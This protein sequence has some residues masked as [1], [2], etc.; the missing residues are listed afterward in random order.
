[1][2]VV[3]S[4][5][6]A[7]TARTGYSSIIVGARSGGTSTPRSG[8][9]RTRRSAT[10]SPPSLR[11]SSTSIA[12]PISRSVVEQA[13]AQRVGHHAFEDHVGARHDQRG[14]QREGG[15][16]R[17]GRHRDRRRPELGLAGQRDAAAVRAMRLDPDVGAEMGE[18]ALGV[19]AAS[20]RC[21]ITVVSPGAAR[22][23]SSTAD[24]SCAE[25]TGGS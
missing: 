6:A 22:P 15:R 5:N 7:A 4:A 8:R 18:H 21:S 10:S 13:G 20:P 16:G 1:M 14:D 12:A 2:R 11:V 17:I 19:V 25:A 24:L 23:A 9:A 3:P